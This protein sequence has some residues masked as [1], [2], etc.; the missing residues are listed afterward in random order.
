MKKLQ[1]IQNKA[2]HGALQCSCRANVK[3]MHG[4]LR[5]LFVRFYQKCNSN[6]VCKDDISKK[7]STYFAQ[8]EH[9]TRHATEG[10]N[11]IE[12]WNSLPGY[13]IQ[14]SAKDGFKKHRIFQY[15]MFMF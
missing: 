1:A 5:W 13:I 3:D 8:H 11:T 14:A 6:T 4:S 7:L 15:F 12:R 9:Q 10:E 2:A